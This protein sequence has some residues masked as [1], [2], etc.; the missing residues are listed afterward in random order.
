MSLKKP[1]SQEFIDA[2]LQSVNTTYIP[3]RF[4][5]L[6]CHYGLR[7]NTLHGLMSTTGAGKSSLMKCIITE[8]AEKI[9]ILVWLSEESVIEYQAKINRMDRDVLGN[10]TF[11]EEKNID[12]KF[13]QNIDSFLEYFDQ[14]VEESGCKM[15]FIDNVTTSLFYNS[16]FGFNGQTRTAEHF[17]NFVKTKCSILYAIHTKKEIGDNHRTIIGSN[18]NRG[19]ADITIETEYLYIIQKFTKNDQIYNILRN[20]KHRFHDNADGFFLLGFDRGTYIGDEKIPFATVN[21]IFVKRDYLG[22]FQKKNR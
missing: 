19:L 7:P 10:I 20:A 9:P 4:N 21:D 5:F 14:M 6:N 12:R 16:R 18:D 2:H 22:R 1:E 15:V 11:V 3:S 17:T 13:K 8:T